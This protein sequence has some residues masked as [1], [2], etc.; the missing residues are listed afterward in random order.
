MPPLKFT[1]LSDG[2]TDANLIPI[3]TWTL[4]EAANVPIAQGSWADLQ[5][6][7]KLPNSFAEKI[8]SAI[9]LFPCDILFVHRDAER[10]SP[11][12]RYEEIRGAFEDA[13]GSESTI[14]AVALVPVR[15]M[16]AWL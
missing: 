12:K 6:L 16:E 9:D 4:R 2:P 5:R 14:P 3:I 7:P 11:K 10:D 15:M 13:F 8:R 1:L